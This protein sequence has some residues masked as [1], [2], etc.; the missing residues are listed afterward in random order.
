MKTRQAELPPIVTSPEIEAARREI[1]G[2]YWGLA[3]ETQK[4]EN[5]QP[6]LGTRKTFTKVYRGR[7]PTLPYRQ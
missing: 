5:R 1:E 2:G 4:E 3:A 6:L 7:P